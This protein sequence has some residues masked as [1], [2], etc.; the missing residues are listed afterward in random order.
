MAKKA[1]CNRACAL[2]ILTIRAQ[3]CCDARYSDHWATGLG[4][5]MVYKQEYKANTLCNKVLKL[6][7]NKNNGMTL[8]AKTK[9]KYMNNII[10]QE[11]T[12]YS[13]KDI[14]ATEISL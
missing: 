9:N 3:I 6:S 12:P 2:N 4:P 14:V 7:G 13:G 8:K 1:L 10:K 11:T 5:D